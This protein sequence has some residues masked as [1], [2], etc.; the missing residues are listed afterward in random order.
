MVLEKLGD[1]LKNTL[2]KI[3]KAIFVDEKLINELIKDLQRALLQ[4]DTN[5]QLVFDLSK[6]IKERAKQDAPPGI[7]KKE[8]LVKI[9]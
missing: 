4:A 1:S 2:T 7:T 3:T 8:Q 5:V 9:V 6:I